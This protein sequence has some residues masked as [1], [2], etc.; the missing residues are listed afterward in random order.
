MGPKFDFYEVVRVLPCDIVP[1]RLWGTLGV[2]LGLT[3]DEGSVGW[4]YAV[5][6][7]SDDDL[8]WQLPER[9]LQS[10]GRKLTRQELY[11]DDSVTVIVDP[12]TGTGEVKT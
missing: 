1:A 4:E 11:A 6:M 7:F 8:C 12:K 3:D 10:D 2:V 9:T 5:Q